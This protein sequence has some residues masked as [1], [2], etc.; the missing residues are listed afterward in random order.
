M[1]DAQSKYRVDSLIGNLQTKIWHANID[2]TINA[3]AAE[4]IGKSWQIRQTSSESYGG[5]HYNVSSG[6][7]ESF[8]YDV[9]P[10]SFTKL[11][12]GG[13]V[14]EHTVEG[15]VFQ[16]GRIW[17]NDKTHLFAQFKQQKP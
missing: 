14:N 2:P 10:Q 1:G 4:T 6:E 12:K 7:N 13:T 11:K 17:N 9:P 15:I 3:Q 5:E 16:S 8:D